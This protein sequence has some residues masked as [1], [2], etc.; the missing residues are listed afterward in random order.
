MLDNFAC[1][2]F[3]EF[4][5]STLKKSFRITIDLSIKQF[6]GPDLNLNILQR[7]SAD[8]TNRQQIV[9][10]YANS[11]SVFYCRFHNSYL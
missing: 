7:L 8:N 1:F 10:I 5:V 2:C 3:V 6:V 9:D 4:S 11:Y